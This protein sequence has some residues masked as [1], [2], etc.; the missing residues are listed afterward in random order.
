[1]TALLFFDALD[2][3]AAIWQ[4]LLAWIALLAAVGSLL[5][6]GTVAGLV[7]VCRTVWRGLRRAWVGACG[8]YRG[9]R[10]SS[11]AETAPEPAGGRTA[12]SWTQTEPQRQEAA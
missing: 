11:V 9:L 8:P 2:A 4:A 6:L 1:M 7:R 10:D 5:L 3:A 12:H